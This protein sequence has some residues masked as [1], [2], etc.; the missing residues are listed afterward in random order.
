MSPALLAAYLNEAIQ[1]GTPLTVRYH[2][3]AWQR[4]YTILPIMATTRLLRAR[5]L[6]TMR[7][8]IFLLRDLQI[9]IDE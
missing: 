8:R 2:D 4:V 9:V 6:V 7:W 5:D 3:G 1:A